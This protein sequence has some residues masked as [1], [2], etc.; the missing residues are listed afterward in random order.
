MLAF[1][2]TRPGLRGLSG[3]RPGPPFKPI[4]L[5]VRGRGDLQGIRAVYSQRWERW[6]VQDQRG[7]RGKDL[8]SEGGSTA[9]GERMG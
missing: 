4:R 7:C 9:P 3:V 5:G 8:R 1:G 2:L 6:G